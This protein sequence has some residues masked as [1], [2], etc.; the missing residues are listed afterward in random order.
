MNEVEQT[1]RLRSLDEKALVKLQKYLTKNIA[2]IKE[3]IEQTDLE[4]SVEYVTQRA[5]LFPAILAKY[6]TVENLVAQNRDSFAG[7]QSRRRARLVTRT[8]R[9]RQVE[10]RLADVRAGASPS[11]EPA[12]VDKETQRVWRRL[13]ADRREMEQYLNYSKKR[14]DERAAGV[15]ASK[16]AELDKRMQ[17]F[18]EREVK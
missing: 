14:G 12:I 18:A 1:I 4:M 11:S 8:R 7:T 3:S 2:E 15:F 13:V 17:D 16:V 9:L 10:Q 5:Q 6:G